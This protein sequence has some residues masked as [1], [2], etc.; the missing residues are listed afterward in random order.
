MEEC[1]TREEREATL[2]I[3]IKIKLKQ[4]LV[5]NI[6][7]TV[8]KTVKQEATDVNEKAKIN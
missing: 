7:L 8:L 6:D 4:S 5:V 2:G 3:F 1:A